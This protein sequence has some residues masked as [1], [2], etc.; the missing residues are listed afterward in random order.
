[1][2]FSDNM[3]AILLLTGPL[4][5]GSSSEQKPLSLSAWSS[6]RKWLNQNQRE[7]EDLFH[8]ENILH[9]WLPTYP[10][11]KNL[12]VDQIGQLLDRGLALADAS[13]RWQQAGIW[14]MTYLDDDYPQRLKKRISG[15]LSNKLPPLF[16]GIGDRALLQRGGLA[17]VGS[18]NAP[19]EDLEYTRQLG[20]AA[21]HEEVV[22]VSGGAKGVDI[23]AMNGCLEEGGNVVGVLSNDLFR[24]SM[25]RSC[26]DYLENDQLVFISET[27]PEV[28]LSRFEFLSAA[29]GRNKYIYCLSD[30]A[31]VVRSGKK[32]GTIS[33][34]TENLKSSWVPLWMK[35]TQEDLS[36]EEES[37][38]MYLQ[39]ADKLPKNEKKRLKNLQAQKMSIQ[40]MLSAPKLS[41]DEGAKEHLRSVL[42]FV[43]SKLSHN[44]SSVGSDQEEVRT[45]VILLTVK[46]N[47]DPEEH[48][49]PMSIEEWSNF[50][51]F[52]M[53]RQLTPAHLLSSSVGEILQEWNHS[54]VTIERI[55]MLLDEG[56][57][58]RLSQYKQSW[59][60]SKIDVVIRSD[61]GYPKILKTRLV[62]KSPPVLFVAGKPDL[63][64]AN[65]P[66]IT[67]LGS[68]LGTN[69]FDIDYARS[70][71]ISMTNH[72]SILISTNKTKLEKMAVQGSLE[73]GGKCIMILNGN[74]KKI[75]ANPSFNK[76][77]EEGRLA[78]VSI[79]PPHA[80]STSSNEDECYDIAC[81]LSSTTLV[82]R[83]GKRDII[84]RCVNRCIQRGWTPVFRNSVQEI[85]ESRMIAENG[86]EQLPQGS[87][88]DDHIKFILS[89]ENS[90][91][92]PSCPYEEV[93]ST[94]IVS[95]VEEFSLA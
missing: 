14:V 70:L 61:S 38:L 52:L 23:T 22:I 2:E 56:R 1:M 19:P 26:R 46:L 31:V 58:D 65:N 69:E 8:D 67:V 39:K 66:N 29:M 93:L 24:R 41:E 90:M 72:E 92:E 21:A 17:V 51:K 47:S 82:I 30:A 71:G 78:I 94:N 27:D 73:S 45:A 36:K 68:A 54:S 25:D 32:G 84:A 12:S 87:S 85:P 15:K 4:G 95:N 50:A 40:Q 6:L 89:G 34:A 79:S 43:E 91:I 18:R 80:K 10:H 13:L 53:E 33:G 3:R 83:S 48:V 63:L 57:R 7:P 77:I 86:Y 49:D 16:F 76:C 75:L 62:H 74:L 28:K 9:D 81:C 60:K 11:N 20:H 37:E 64:G 5:N 42:G 55:N 59:R 35:T 44:A 88:A